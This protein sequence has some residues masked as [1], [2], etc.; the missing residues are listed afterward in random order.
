MREVVLHSPEN[1]TPFSSFGTKTRLPGNVDV[2]T[3]PN[4]DVSTFPPEGG[5]TPGPAGENS[6]HTRTRQRKP[7]L[8]PGTSGEKPASPPEPPAKKQAHPLELR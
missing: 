2:S 7:R 8:T 1:G 3:F 6:L 5:L 4:V